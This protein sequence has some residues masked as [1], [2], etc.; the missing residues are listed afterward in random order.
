M[1][2]W[3]PAPEIAVTAEIQESIGGHPYVAQTL[4]RRGLLELDA[5]RGFLD[6]DAYQ[7]ASPFAF[8]A[9]EKAVHRLSKAIQNHE[10]ICVWGDFDVDGQTSTTLLVSALSALGA[11]VIFHIPNRQNESHGINLPYLKRIMDSGAHLILTCDTG[12]SAA[13]EVAYAQKRNM[14]VI[15][16]DHH[17]LPLSLPDAYAIINPKMLPSGHSLATLPGVG[18]AYKLAEA[19]HQHLGDPDICHSYLDL[20]ALGIV[21]DLALLTG[22]TRYLLQKGI[23]RLR[24]TP[25]IGMQVMMEIA[26][27]DLEFLNEEHIAFEL[28]PRLNTLGRLSDANSIVDFFTTPDIGKA[29]SLAYQL[30]MLNEQRKLQTKQVF[31]AAL[32][33]IKDNPDYLEQ[34]ALVLAHP[35]WPA[36]IIGIVASRLVER[37]QK[38]VLLI[39]NPYGEIGRGSARSVA[40]IN[41][42]AAIA[43]QKEMLSNFGGHPMA[44][45]FSIPLGP[46]IEIT[47]K[48]FRKAISQ[49]IERMA[50]NA[51]PSQRAFDGYLPLN[52]LS[53]ELVDD[54]ER[55]APF[56]PGNPA[57]TLVSQGMEIVDQSPIG[58]TQEHLILSVKDENQNVFRL[59]WWQGAGWQ[60]PEGK[61][62]LLYRARSII[63]SGKKS[64]QLEWI[65]SKPVEAQSIEVH[66]RKIIDLIDYRYESNPI[67][68]LQKIQKQ[69]DIQI[70]SEGKHNPNHSL[71]RTVLVPG[72]D[73]AIWTSPPG[74]NEIRS[75]LNGVAPEKVYLFAINPEM[76]SFNQFIE[77]LS[78]MIKYAI[79]HYQ[80]HLDL[81]KLAA[82]SAHQEETVLAGIEWLQ[83]A[84]Y[85]VIR[86]QDRPTLIVDFGNKNPHKDLPDIQIKLN[87]LLEE[88]AAFRK[89][90][91]IRDRELLHKDFNV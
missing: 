79:T 65:D 48:K 4:A 82:K 30:E 3:I 66:D 68:T 22:D 28:A 13:D 44:A 46:D 43:E 20:V 76:D 59:I 7:P 35:T 40:G 69:A 91:K 32:A 54:F 57:L 90:L 85:I 70:W 42:T 62:D 27:L 10:T 80:G 11:K 18:V 75:V 26:E 89:M 19:L 5:I 51:A 23:Q 39:S 1:N 25:R 71:D 53:L 15:I 29:R 9:M 34:P 38:P 63:T 17:D 83:A 47:I 84:G 73:L 74:W 45:G 33:Q 49:T 41:I 52:Q 78:G 37:Y 86:P 60:L 36:G 87:F 50:A 6:P 14:D 16:T 88:T 81:S 56:G 61:F 8:P 77:Q 12:I 21:A 72:K 67:E 24:G 64:I 31:Q 2:H 58:K 55:L